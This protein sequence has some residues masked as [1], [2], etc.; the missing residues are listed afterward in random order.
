MDVLLM[1]KLGVPNSLSGKESTCQCGRCKRFEFNPWAGKKP[2]RKKWQPTPIYLPGKF[3]GQ[4]N[5]TGCSPWGRKQS[6]VTEQLSDWACTDKPGLQVQFFFFFQ[7]LNINLK[8]CL[9]LSYQVISKRLITNILD[10]VSDS[11]IILG[12]NKIPTDTNYDFL[13][14]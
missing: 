7:R 8:Q 10:Q 13:F 2:W 4:R 6:K 11:N 5:L 9:Y 1:C 3:Q 12:N 14:I